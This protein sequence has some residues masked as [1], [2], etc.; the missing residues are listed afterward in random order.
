V[1]A[2]LLPS[3]L[4]SGQRAAIEHVGGP[5]LIVAGPGAGKTDVMVRRT[6]YL[7]RE[8]HARPEQVLVTTFTNKAA[9]ELRDRLYEFLDRQAAAVHISTI[10]SLCQT[11]L[12]RYPS[13]HRWGP[14]M[15]VL[16]ETGQFLLVFSRLSD[17]GVN[18]A[19]ECPLNAA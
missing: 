8:R 13:K 18:A 11:L 1:H 3:H 6:V 4:T 17:L 15:Q 16:D 12:E 7:V 10:H 19:S 5:L 14:G 9:D 2:E